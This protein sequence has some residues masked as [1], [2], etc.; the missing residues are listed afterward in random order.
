MMFQGTKLH[1]PRGS[2]FV[3]V[4][5]IGGRRSRYWCG[6]GSVRANQNGARLSESGM[7][8]SISKITS[9]LAAGGNTHPGSWRSPECG[10]TARGRPHNPGLHYSPGRKEREPNVRTRTRF[11][12]V[13]AAHYFNCDTIPSLMEVR[14]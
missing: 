13:H 14:A 10:N 11:T 9:R 4:K 3:N 6:P 12:H 8:R 5:T 2:V 1:S 7:E